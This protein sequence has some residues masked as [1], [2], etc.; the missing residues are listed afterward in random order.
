MF[1]TNLFSLIY[2]APTVSMNYVKVE[3]TYTDDGILFCQMADDDDQ[4][5]KDQEV[6]VDESGVCLAI[7]CDSGGHPE[8][9]KVRV[10]C[11]VVTSRPFTLE[12]MT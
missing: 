4:Y 11:T 5:F 2:A 6:I 12:D 8:D 3:T 1:T 7:S 10:K 9:E